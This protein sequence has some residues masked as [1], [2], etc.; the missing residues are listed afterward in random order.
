MIKVQGKKRAFYIQIS[1]HLLTDGPIGL[2]FGRIDSEYAS[3][4]RFVLLKCQVLISCIELM[5]CHMALVSAI[6]PSC[7]V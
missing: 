4:S 5:Q 3:R 2:A 6:N 7:V 1:L